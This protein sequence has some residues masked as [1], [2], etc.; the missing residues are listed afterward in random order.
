MLFR[1]VNLDMLGSS[2]KLFQFNWQDMYSLPFEVAIDT[3]I[4]VPIQ[5]SSPYALQ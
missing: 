4:R 5:M 3:H 1:R 2:L